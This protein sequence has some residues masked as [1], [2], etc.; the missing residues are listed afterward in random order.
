LEQIKGDGRLRPIPVAV[1][2]SS[3]RDEDVAKSYGLG[4]NHF[5]T[6]PEDVRDL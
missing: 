4:G 5:I 1:L 6:K 2:S 3:D